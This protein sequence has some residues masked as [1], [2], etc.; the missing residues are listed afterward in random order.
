MNF[1]S[2]HFISLQASEVILSPPPF[3]A[4]SFFT[5]LIDALVYAEEMPER[6]PWTVIARRALFIAASSLAL[7]I[8]LITVL[9]IWLIVLPYFTIII[10]RSFFDG[11]TLLVRFVGSILRQLPGSVWHGTSID[12][13]SGIPSW[14]NIGSD[15]YEGKHSYLL[16]FV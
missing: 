12:F 5:S 10:W 9:F 15:I 4:L 7:V 13:G 16:S 2:I 11:R 3:T 6:L 14:A 8:R 1:A